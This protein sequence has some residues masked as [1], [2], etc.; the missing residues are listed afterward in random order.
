MV[1]QCAWC[2]RL[3]DS[4]GERVSLLPLPKLYKA[5]HGMCGV[6]GTLLMEQAMQT[7]G[8][9]TSRETRKP[10]ASSQ[11]REAAV[12]FLPSATS[13]PQEAE[14]QPAELTTTATVTQL[15]LELQQ[16]EH[17]TPK[18]RLRTRN[19]LRIR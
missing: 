16:R 1:R 3:I 7:P 10:V 9:E 13:E 17:E 4:A 18:P 14:H 2:L 11:V 6:C 15:V 5:S 19:E 8:T 12:S